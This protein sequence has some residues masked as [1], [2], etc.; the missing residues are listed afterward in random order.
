MIQKRSDLSVRRQCTL[1]GVNRATLY[2]KGK[3]P[4]EEARLFREKVMARI[5][6]WHTKMPAIGSRKISVLLQQEGLAAG[7]KMVRNCMTEMAIS[8]I[9][10]K[11]NLS[12]RNFKQAIVPYLL[13]NYPIRYPNQAW[14]I[15]ITYIKMH[16]SHMYLTAII[17]WFSRKIVGWNLSDTLDTDS[18]I[19]AVK[20]AIS[21]HGIPA[22]LNSDQ[23]CQFT[24]EEY[25]A[26]LRSL[27][28]RQ[29][30]DGKSRWADNI[31]I[32]R[33]FRSLKSEKIYINEYHNPKALRKD[34]AEYI[35][36]Y[37]EVRPHEAIGYITPSQRFA[38]CFN[39]AA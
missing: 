36:E 15:D 22:I 1:L 27:G 8:A 32:E 35:L 17:D 9:Y 25:K 11:M 20:D 28:I 30:M 39:D 2:Y 37:N 5:D 29:S 24:S 12:K 33:W 14:S 16:Q 3:E 7:R 34:I 26:Y 38:E 18:V 31:M 13:R 10:P 19:T 6:Y 4:D 21:T 23:G